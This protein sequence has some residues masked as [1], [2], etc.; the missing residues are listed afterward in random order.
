MSWLW[1]RET[2]IVNLSLPFGSNSFFAISEGLFFGFGEE[3]LIYIA[4]KTI[5]HITEVIPTV[6]RKIEVCLFIISPILFLTKKGTPKHI[7]T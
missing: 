4:P 2:K 1:E 7:Y 6:L 5:K 3:I